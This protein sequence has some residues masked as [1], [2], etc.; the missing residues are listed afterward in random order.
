MCAI[1]GCKDDFA[2]F[3]TGTEDDKG[4]ATIER[5]SVAYEWLPAC[6]VAIV[7]SHDFRVAADRERQHVVGLRTDRPV[8]VD[9]RHPDMHKV[10]AVG[11]PR[12]LVGGKSK[13]LRSDGST[14]AMTRHDL[15]IAVGHSF[16]DSRLIDD[17]IPFYLVTMVGIRS[18]AFPSKAAS[19]EEELHLLGIGIG[20][21][22]I[23]LPGV[24]FQ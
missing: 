20:V 1:G 10:H 2:T 19:V 9:H 15:S 24:R 8:L 17:I 22:G 14:Y 6:D 23:R 12:R 3:R 5:A 21:E 7:D 16:Q 4:R 18:I 13:G 11:L